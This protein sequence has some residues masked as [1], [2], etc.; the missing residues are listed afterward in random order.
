MYL[1]DT[2]LLSFRTYWNLFLRSLYWPYGKEELLVFS[3]QRHH[4]ECSGFSTHRRLDCLLN[5]FFR[6]R[7]KKTSKLPVTGL[8]CVIQ[9]QIKE[10]IKAPHH[11]PL[12]GE[13]TGD[14]WIPRPHKGPVTRKMFPF[15][16]VIMFM[17][18]NW[19]CDW[20]ISIYETESHE[21]ETTH[22]FRNIL[23]EV[24]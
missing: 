20:S 4:N 1:E 17:L 12:C 2:A 9:A 23:C 16:D 13:V 15:D 5:R 18:S 3:S 19:Y 21:R 6:R 14:R 8:C 11:W 10:N 24:T 7:S 22:S